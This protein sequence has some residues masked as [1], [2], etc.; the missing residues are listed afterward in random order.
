MAHSAKEY[1][2]NFFKN[3]GLKAETEEKQLQCEYLE[4]KLLDSM[5]IV[6][7]VVELENEFKIQFSPEDLQAEKFRTVGGLIQTVE[8]LSAHH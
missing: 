4:E 2:L 7:M 8:Q 5:G 3:K 1:V 6:E